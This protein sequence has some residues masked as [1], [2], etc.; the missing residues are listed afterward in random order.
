M[1]SKLNRPTAINKRNKTSVIENGFREQGKSTNTLE[2]W[3]RRQ[4]LVDLWNSEYVGKKGLDGKD[5]VAHFK[6]IQLDGQNIVIHMFQENPIKYIIQDPNTDSTALVPGISQI[7]GRKRNTDAP[8]WIDTPFPLIDK[9]VIMAISPYVQL[10]YYELKDKL[11]KYDRIAADKII[12]PQV[13][14]VVYTNHFLFKESRYYIDKQAKTID[15]IRN[16]EEIRLDKFDF[17]FKVS[18]YEIESIVKRDAFD[19]MY[20]AVVPIEKRIQEIKDQ[21]NRDMLNMG[22]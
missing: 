9:G 3:V 4:H 12:I 2:E 17:L 18:T 6:N 1:A 10:Y 20:D 16:Q 8:H 7:D 11:A 13:G 14:D 5:L 21:A 19:K 22:G 15:F